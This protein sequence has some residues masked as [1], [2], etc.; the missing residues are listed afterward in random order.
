M[1]HSP[2]LIFAGIAVWTLFLLSVPTFA[3][4]IQHFVHPQQ[5]S[6]YVAPTSK[7]TIRIV[8]NEKRRGKKEV[9]IAELESP[10]G[11]DVP[12]HIPQS[13]EIFYILSGEL[14]QTSGR[15]GLH[16]LD[17]PDRL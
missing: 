12:D 5:T 4:D 13:T 14:E 7:S 3:E 15:Y 16:S 1:Q 6:T 9:S 11:M 10:L 8:I 2:C 17:R